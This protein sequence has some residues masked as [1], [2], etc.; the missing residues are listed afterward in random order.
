[1]ARRKSNRVR[2]EDSGGWHVDRSMNVATM[3]GVLLQMGVWIWFL[4]AL[5]TRVGD[6]ER[7]ETTIEGA[8][9]DSRVSTMESALKGMSTQL[10]RMDGKLDQMQMRIK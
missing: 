8:R 1:M 3:L 7:Q 5:S 4:S 2:Q 6:L 10:D 9:L